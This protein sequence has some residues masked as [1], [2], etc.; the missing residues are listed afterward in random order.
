MRKHL[1][2]ISIWAVALVAAVSLEP[3][4][5]PS[6][7][8]RAAEPPPALAI[9]EGKTPQGFPYLFGGVSSDEREAIEGRA[10]DYNVKLIFAEKNGPFVAGVTVTIADAKGAEIASVAT[11]GPWF[12]ILLPPGQYNV[13][14]TFQGQ[15]KEVKNLT[16]RKN[17]IVRQTL[18]WDLGGGGGP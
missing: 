16:V 1:T 18:V 13:K 2:R 3:A 12:L 9:T 11:D 6:A 15:T 8:L 14:A 5:A 10:K 7:D 4:R 17:E